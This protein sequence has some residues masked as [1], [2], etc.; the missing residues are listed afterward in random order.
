MFLHLVTDSG[1][2]VIAAGVILGVL[3]CIFYGLKFFYVLKRLIKQRKEKQNAY[4]FL[5]KIK[6]LRII[7]ISVEISGE[8]IA[9]F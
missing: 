5:R 2:Q 8:R 6:Q 4:V 3:V 7:V 1:K 9:P